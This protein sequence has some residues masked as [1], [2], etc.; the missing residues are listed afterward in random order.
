MIIDYYPQ[1]VFTKTIQID[2]IGN[3]ALRATSSDESEYYMIVKTVMGKTSVL[4]FGPTIPDIGI[5]CADYS[6]N[7]K[8]MNFKEGAIEKEASI[9]INDHK[10]DIVDAVEILPEEAIEEIPEITLDSLIGA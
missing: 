2:D 10:K 7:Y 1:E 8:K 5:L 6:M 9:F 3:F 4:K